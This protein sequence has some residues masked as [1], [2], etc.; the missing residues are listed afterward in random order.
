[1]IAFFHPILKSDRG[2]QWIIINYLLLTIN[3]ED[4]SAN[5]NLTTAA[6]IFL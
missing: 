6:P 5:A 3:I 4:R 1:M 2:F